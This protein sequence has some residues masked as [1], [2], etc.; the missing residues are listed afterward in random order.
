MG[1]EIKKY[2]LFLFFVC[3]TSV[4]HVS[5]VEGKLPSISPLNFYCALFHKGPFNKYVKA[6][7]LGGYSVLHDILFYSIDLIYCFS[8]MKRGGWVKAV[9]FCVTYL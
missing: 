5:W 2:V 3:F 9:M 8:I 7:K 4:H 6:V 1:R